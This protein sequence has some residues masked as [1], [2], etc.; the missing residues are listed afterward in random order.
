MPSSVGR[1]KTSLTTPSV[2]FVWSQDSNV[3]LCKYERHK[4][5][6]QS[7]SWSCRTISALQIG[8]KSMDHQAYN[9]TI[10]NQEIKIRY[11]N[12]QPA[13]ITMCRIVKFCNQ[14]CAP[15]CY[16]ANHVTLCQP[17]PHCTHV[18]P[19]YSF[20]G[21]SRLELCCACRERQGMENQLKEFKQRI[22]EV[23]EGAAGMEQEKAEEGKTKSL[24]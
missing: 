13:T 23:Q 8:A 19:V 21:D 2:A 3:S 24:A 4:G 1:T 16:H 20:R 9:Q 10:K 6:A 17:S 11:N 22:N 12:N 18:C 7:S 15:V 14:S 5:I